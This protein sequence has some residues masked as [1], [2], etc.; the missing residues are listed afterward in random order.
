MSAPHSTPPP[1]IKELIEG[2][3]PGP[4]EAFPEGGTVWA[5]L[6]KIVVSSPT[7]NGHDAQLIARCNPSVMRE[8]VEALELAEQNYAR[9]NH[10]QPD[11]MGDDEH[12]AWGAVRHALSLLSSTAN[13]ESK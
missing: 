4:W 10:S 7:R 1:T 6:G 5:S 9:T 11:I 2:A 13:P 12:E 8:V 3:T